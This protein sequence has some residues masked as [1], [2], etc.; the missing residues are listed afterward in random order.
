MFRNGG[1]QTHN[2]TG[3]DEYMIDLVL[4]ELPNLALETPTMYH[5][6]GLLYLAAV[7]EK[8][9]YSVEIADFRDGEKEL[10][11]A[12]YYGFSCTTPEI[13]EAKKLAKQVK[14]KTI[15]GGAHPS[16]LPDDCLE[17]FDYIVRGEGE[18]VLLDILAG[19]HEGKKLIYAIR[20]M[21]L[22]TIPYP[23]WGKVKEPFSETLFTGERYGKG[24]KS[25]AIITSRGCPYRCSFC[26]NIYRVPVVYRSPAN[27]AGEVKE[28]L[29]MGIDHLR[30]VD[31]NFTMHPKFEDIC[32]DL[33]SLGVIY[34]CH[35][36]SDLLTRKQAELLKFSG[37]EECSLGIESADKAVLKLN[38]KKE[39]P[40]QHGRAIEYLR[41]AGL[42]TKTYL[43]SGLPGETDET[44]EINKAFMRE[45]K[46]DKWTLSTFTPYPGCDIY[47]NPSK[48]NIEIM[49]PN[50]DNWWNFVMPVKGKNLPGRM[51]YVHKLK[52]QTLEEM[53]ERHDRF[54]EWL[55]KG[56]WKCK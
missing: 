25:A 44:M 56:E 6:L 34:R 3:S 11:E 29:S 12:R 24:A 26:S 43:M 1:K 32:L 50:W 17:H 10:P 38:N 53:G 8:S 39:T 47:A 4:V 14:G 36:R 30:F 28:L 9:G 20:I 27:I 16:L 2:E 48:Y 22:D 46:P 31:D 7:V 41:S 13:N 49:N 42:R 21:D 40:E 37:C 33:R 55:R 23:A 15:V 52:G 35:T 18:R 51:G 5:P 45:Y 54:Y 19:L